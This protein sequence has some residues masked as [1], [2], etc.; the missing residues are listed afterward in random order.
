MSEEHIKLREF[1][2]AILEER[3]RALELSAKAIDA[4]LE[5]VNNLRADVIRDRELFVTK[6]AHEQS[7]GELLRRLNSIESAQQRIV[8]VGIAMVVFAGIIGAVIERV[9]R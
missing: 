2:E 7:Q 4:K 1:I 9:F 3:Q 6:A 5:H 8:G